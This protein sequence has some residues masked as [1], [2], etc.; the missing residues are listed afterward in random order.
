METEGLQESQLTKK[1]GFIP[2][3]EHQLPNSVP[4]KSLKYAQQQTLK[5]IY[6]HTACAEALQKG[7]IFSITPL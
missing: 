1:E 6:C 7:V 3:V 4:A 5:K 2:G